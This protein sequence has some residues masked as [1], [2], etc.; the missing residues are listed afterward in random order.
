MRGKFTGS[1]LNGLNLTRNDEGFQAA[2]RAENPFRSLVLVKALD[3]YFGSFQTIELWND[4][5]L[6][7]YRDVII[8]KANREGVEPW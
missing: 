7:E 2:C 6:Q 4:A 8:G 5:S 1:E 3:G